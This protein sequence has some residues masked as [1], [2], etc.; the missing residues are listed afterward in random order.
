LP[1]PSASNTRLIRLCRFAVNNESL[2]R[3][4]T[5]VRLLSTLGWKIR[6]ADSSVGRRNEAGAIYAS[7][8]LS[9]ECYMDL[10]LPF[11]C[12]PVGGKKSTAQP[13]NGSYRPAVILMFTFTGAPIYELCACLTDQRSVSDMSS[14]CPFG[15]RVTV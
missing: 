2:D 7:K 15:F 6:T 12:G 13:P 3:A 11:A 10:I 14:C 9:D 8:G 1:R 4:V 5:Q